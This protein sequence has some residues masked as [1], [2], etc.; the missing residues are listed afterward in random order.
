MAGVASGGASSVVTHRA[1]CAVAAVASPG[2]W[3]AHARGGV[4]HAD[5]AQSSGCA[6]RGA[7]CARHTVYGAGEAVAVTA[8]RMPSR[9]DGVDLQ[10]LLEPVREF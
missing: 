1:G 8:A 2:G 10:H 6:V 5:D 9:L 7:G 3:Q 4:R